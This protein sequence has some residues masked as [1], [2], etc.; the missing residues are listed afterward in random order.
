MQVLIKLIDSFTQ[1][2][3]IINPTKIMKMLLFEVK[4]KQPSATV[5]GSIWHLVGLLHKNYPTVCNYYLEETQKQN[6]L[7][8][9][10]KVRAT[11]PEIKEII[12]IMKGLTHSLEVS[13]KLEVPEIDS[14]FAD[15][16]TFIQPLVE[17]NNR[18]VMK[19]GMKLLS[20]HA[21]LF[22]TQIME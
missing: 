15:L 13:C 3:P 10:E 5:A 20:T 14:L 2:E 7:L 17:V 9:D 4:S 1:I 16:K 22:A 19:A 8:L 18:G 11:K 21:C 6:L 12:G